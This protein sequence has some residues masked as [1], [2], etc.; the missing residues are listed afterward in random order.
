MKI[1]IACVKASSSCTEPRNIFH[2]PQKC[3]CN[4]LVKMLIALDPHGYFDQILH[5]YACHIV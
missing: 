1:K 5:M 3:Y 2:N 4:Q